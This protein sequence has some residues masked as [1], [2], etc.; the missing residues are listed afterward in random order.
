MSASKYDMVLKYLKRRLS[1]LCG[2][3]VLSEYEYLG[4]DSIVRQSIILCY[5][6]V[7]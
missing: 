1:V 7:I 2:L 5:I 3:A 6:E 4:I